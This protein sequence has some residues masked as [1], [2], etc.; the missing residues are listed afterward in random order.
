[1]KVQAINNNYRNYN[2]NF[3]HYVS[4]VLTTPKCHLGRN[5]CKPKAK[6]DTATKVMNGAAAVGITQAIGGA[7]PALINPESLNNI[8]LF[9]ALL[10]SGF[11]TS[12]VG[13]AESKKIAD[14]LKNKGIL[15]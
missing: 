14:F 10:I 2:T 15:K 4:K 13:M 6:C 9:G 11:V 1:M 5:I 7:I 8:I 3:G 12:V